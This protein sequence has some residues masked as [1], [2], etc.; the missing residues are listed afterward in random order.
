MHSLSPARAMARRARRFFITGLIILLVGLVLVAIGIALIV[1]PLTL[2][3]W[4][5]LVQAGAII[6]GL[7]TALVG[8]IFVVRGLTFPTE[9][10]HA[11]KVAGELA[12]VLDY[13]YTFI[14]NL[15]RR[16]LGYI[17]GVLVGPNGALAFYFFDRK[18]AYYLEG[19]IWFKQAGDQLRPLNQN[20]TREV[21]KDVAALRAYLAERELSQVPVYAVIVLPF[22]GT[23]VTA[24]RPVV[25]VSHLP[26]LIQ[27]LRDNYF[28]A[29]RIPAQL[30]KAT[31]QAI[32]DE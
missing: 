5:S 27:V 15:S 18:G 11:L 10:Q 25:P 7:V 3:D 32:M 4:Y 23:V 9:N 24:E 19:N 31:V 17:D 21:I 8:G 22:K 14:R 1:V 26:T 12:R 28:A 16:G 29:E 2:A 6:V 13:R 30:V 20:P